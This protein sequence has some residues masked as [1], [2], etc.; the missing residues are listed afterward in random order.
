MTP[1]A[2]ILPARVRE[3]VYAIL[4]V[5][6]PGVTLIVVLLN[7]GWQMADLPLILTSVV[8]SAGFTLANNNTKAT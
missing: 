6:V 1:L 7:D 2:G 3:I 8:S 4:A 5:V